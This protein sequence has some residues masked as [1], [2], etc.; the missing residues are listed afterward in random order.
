MLQ[1][2]AVAIPRFSQS[3][4]RQNDDTKQGDTATHAPTAHE[5]A[6][7]LFKNVAVK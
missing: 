1:R 7:A 6:N 3:A 5:L 2:F 4:Q